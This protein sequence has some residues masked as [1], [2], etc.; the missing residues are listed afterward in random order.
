MRQ[1]RRGSFS[2]AIPR[3]QVGDDASGNG[4]PLNVPTFTNASDSREFTSHES[5]PYSCTPH[6]DM[7]GTAPLH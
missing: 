2:R 3:S 1:S 4:A 5:Y 6:A 7:G